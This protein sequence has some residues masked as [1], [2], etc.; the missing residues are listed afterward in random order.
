[1]ERLVGAPRFS[2]T[3]IHPS[4]WNRYSAKFVPEVA[5][6]QMR[7]LPVLANVALLCNAMELTRLALFRG[8]GVKDT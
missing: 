5:I 3:L 6:W 1:V 4:A 8:K 2:L 7:L